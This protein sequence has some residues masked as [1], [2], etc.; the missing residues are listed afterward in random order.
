LSFN[1]LYS[2]VH[3]GPSRI[4]TSFTFLLFFF[5]IF[6][7]LFQLL[8]SNPSL[9][10]FLLAIIYALNFQEPFLAVNV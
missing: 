6:L 1:L 2:C 8:A 9:W 10:L 3:A 7:L 4:I 5:S